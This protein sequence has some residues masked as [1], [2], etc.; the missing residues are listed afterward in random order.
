MSLQI[1]AFPYIFLNAPL[2]LRK[3]G[4]E[5]RVVRAERAITGPQSSLLCTGGDTEAHA[6]NIQLGCF[7]LLYTVSLGSLWGLSLQEQRLSEAVV[8][9]MGHPTQGWGAGPVT[10]VTLPTSRASP[11]CPSQPSHFPGWGWWRVISSHA[12]PCPVP[13]LRAWRPALPSQNP[14]CSNVMM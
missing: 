7:L 9:A 11:R 8:A 10:T 13:W 3:A 5:R 4:M 12:N 2:A 6:P 1:P 14:R